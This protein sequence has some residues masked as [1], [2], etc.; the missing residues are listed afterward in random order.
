[1]NMQRRNFLRAS[2]AGLA[3]AGSLPVLAAGNA[4]WDKTADVVVV[5]AGGAGLAA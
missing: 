4:A 5:G 3:A 1:M 2:A